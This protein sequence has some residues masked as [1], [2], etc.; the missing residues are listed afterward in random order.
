MIIKETCHDKETHTLDIID[1]LCRNGGF[2][3]KGP[4]MWGFDVCFVESPK[5]RMSKNLKMI[6]DTM[7]LVW[8]QC[9]EYFWNILG[10]GYSILDLFKGGCNWSLSPRTGKVMFSSLLV[11][12]LVGLSAT[13]WNNELMDVNEILRIDQTW[14][15]EQTVIFWGC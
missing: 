10:G 14:H 4:L 8:Y 6:W 13:L 11:S 12:L 9:N 7:S 5:N 3:H 2:P 15:K 1:P